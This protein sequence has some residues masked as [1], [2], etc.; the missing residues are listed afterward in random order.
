VEVGG[1]MYGF[2]TIESLAND[3]AVPVAFEKIT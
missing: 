2:P 1:E 3:F